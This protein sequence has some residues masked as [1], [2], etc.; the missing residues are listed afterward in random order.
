MIVTDG[1]FGVKDNLVDAS[2]VAGQ[3]VGDSPA[4]GVPNV[5]KAIGR[6][7]RHLAAVRG[8][9]TAQQVL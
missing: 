3:L 2:I 6:A 7:G 8:P 9:G 4:S 5:D 1:L